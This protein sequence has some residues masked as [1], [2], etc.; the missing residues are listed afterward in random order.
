MK[1]YSME[2]VVGIFVL[3]GLI[4]IGY[5]AVKLGNLSLFSQDTYM[6]NAR[7]TS[8]SGLRPN[9]PV[10]VFGIEVGSV[11]Y[12]GIDN[13]RQ[14]AVVS[15]RI[16]KNVPVYSDATARLDTMGLIGDRYIKIDPGGSGQVLKSGD[17]I[18][19]TVTPPSIDEMIGQYIFG[20]ANG[21][22]KKK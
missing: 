21:N 13:E 10:Q 1:K 18:T 12:M 5:I 2:T 15:M 6:V 22:A 16:K 14:V 7:F 3:V 20:Q 19:N 9:S 11:V 8:V 4:C 17:Y